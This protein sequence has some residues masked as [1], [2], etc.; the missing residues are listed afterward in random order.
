M[1][2]L[3]LYIFFQDG[4]RCAAF[5]SVQNLFK[6]QFKNSGFH[7]SQP[8]MAGCHS[9]LVRSLSSLQ[10]TGLDDSVTDPDS[11]KP[12]PFQFPHPWRDW[13]FAGAGAHNQ[14]PA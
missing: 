10:L 8:S 5:G 14:L 9:L 2:Y 6:M 3:F 7:G 13:S 12:S 4:A 1:L 11:T